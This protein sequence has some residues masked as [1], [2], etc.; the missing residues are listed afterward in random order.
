MVTSWPDDG[1]HA[2]KAQNA[3]PAIF[4]CKCMKDVPNNF[5]SSLTAA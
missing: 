1:S 3:G 2:A 5:P 4:M